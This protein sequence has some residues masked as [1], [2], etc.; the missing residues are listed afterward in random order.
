MASIDWSDIKLIAVTNGPGLAGSLLV[1]VNFAK[2]LSASLGIPV[3]PVN[4]MDGHIYAAW[5][6]TDQN[7]LL[8]F[9]SLV[10]EQNITCLV[11]SGGHTDLAILKKYGEIKL[12]GDKR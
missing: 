12:I 3:F 1:G 4:H 7:K 10:G 8:D 6:K 9:Q 11:V 5:A 2:G